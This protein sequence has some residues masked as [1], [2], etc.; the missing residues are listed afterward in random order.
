MMKGALNWYC[1]LWNLTKDISSCVYPHCF[2]V[3]TIVIVLVPGCLAGYSA[4]KPLNPLEKNT[5]NSC[6]PQWMTQEM[7]SSPS[8]SNVGLPCWLRWADMTLGS[9][10]KLPRCMLPPIKGHHSYDSKLGDSVFHLILLARDR[11]QYFKTLVCS[12]QVFYL[13]IQK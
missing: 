2:I 9:Y 4:P 13:N 7:S 1:P 10:L 12:A 11:L 3:Y 5:Q 8:S 6:S